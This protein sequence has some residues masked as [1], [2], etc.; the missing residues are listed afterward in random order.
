M[1]TK[2]KRTKTKDK[3]LKISKERMDEIGIEVDRLMKNEMKYLTNKYIFKYR[4]S[5]ASVFGW[6]EDDLRQ[7]I[8]I[9]LWKGVATF[10]KTK[11][12]ALTTYLSTIL[13]YQMGN[14]SKS[15]QNQKNSMSKM[16]CP[17]DLY[18]SEFT[19]DFSSS[20]DWLRYSQQ[21]SIL[22]DRMNSL[23]KKVL[24]SHLLRDESITQM[25]KRLKIPR[26]NIVSS[27][28][29]LKDKMESILGDYSE[30]NCLH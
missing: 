25:Q 10:D 7:H 30:K 13:Y 20:E 27:L 17:E 19:T 14:L 3:L 26:P 15:C 22:M 24:V 5:T 18:D 21:F 16:Y 4:N 1:A 11:K 29:S 6:N 23:E 12:V 2:K 28:K 9:I 8:M